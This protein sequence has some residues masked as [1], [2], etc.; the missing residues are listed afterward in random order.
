MTTN[1]LSLPP[2]NL[3]DNCK[4]HEL[5]LCLSLHQLLQPP[6]S[7]DRHHSY[8]ASLTSIIALITPIYIRLVFLFWPQIPFATSNGLVSANIDHY[9]PVSAA[10]TFI[11]MIP[12]QFV[13]FRFW[14]SKSILGRFISEST[15]V[16]NNIF[17]IFLA[18]VHHTIARWKKFSIRVWDV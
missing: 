6:L 8:V 3:D 9:H 14:T 17:N 11:S 4:L 18:K 16:S 15:N 13:L 10:T 5:H 7:S 12:F 2:F 1:S